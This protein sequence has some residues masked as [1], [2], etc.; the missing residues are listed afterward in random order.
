MKRVTL[1]FLFIGSLL[2]AQRCEI[3]SYDRM[4]NLRLHLDLL[5]SDELAGRKPGTEGAIAARNYIG[6]QF[7]SANLQKIFSEGYYQVFPVPNRVEVDKRQTLFILEGINLT[8]NQ[9]FY[10]TKYSANASAEAK[11][12]YVDYGIESEELDR[13][14]VDDKTLPGRIAVMEIGSPDGIHPHS[15]FIAYHDLQLRIENLQ[16]KGAKGV[17]LI[18]SKEQTRDPEKE[19]KSITATDIPVI[20]VSDAE[21]AKDL[22]KTRAAKFTVTQHEK[23]IKAYNV[24]GLLNNEAKKTVVIGAHYDHLGMGGEGSLFRGEEPEIHNGADDNASGTAALIELA[25]FLS[26]TDDENLRRYNY[27]FMA[28]SGEEMGLLGSNYF[29]KNLPEDSHFHFMLNMD[30][31]GRMEEQQLQV[32][33]TGTSPIWE[34]ILKGLECPLEL[35]LSESGVG[36]SDHTSFYYQDVPVLHF[37]T[38]THTDYHKPTDDVEKINFKGMIKTMNLMLSIISATPAEMAFTKTKNESMSAP[39]FSVTLGVMPDYMFDGKGMR[40]DGVTEGRPADKA[41][42]QAGD[43]VTKMGKAT[44][45][46]MMSYM[47]ALGQFK[48]GDE[49]QVEYQRDGKTK[50]TTVQF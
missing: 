44:V 42:L 31:V 32:N 17:I 4:E 5:A 10:A 36:P 16:K 24:G 19:Y 11:T 18:D 22:R 46:D 25:H 9:H 50:T 30:M 49:T 2:Q 23:S 43:I 29:V 48:E 35:K 39:R 8:L 3:I 6:R 28:F 15:E 40:I 7:E 33:G 47:K 34:E 13:D 12:L 20:F 37:F 1:L 41:G 38:G 14:D 26:T 45:R 27:L 21:Y